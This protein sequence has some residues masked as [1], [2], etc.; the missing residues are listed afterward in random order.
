MRYRTNGVNRYS[1]PTS[2]ESADALW[3]RTFC[4][5]VIEGEVLEKVH[6]NSKL[7]RP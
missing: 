7:Q 5:D 3:Q 2:N 6:Q 1:T 4:Q